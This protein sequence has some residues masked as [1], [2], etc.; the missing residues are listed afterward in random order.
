MLLVEVR[1]KVVSKEDGPEN[2]KGPDVGM[3]AKRQWTKQLRMLNLR[4][5]HEGCHGGQ[6]DLR[7]PNGLL[8]ADRGTRN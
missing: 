6:I 7:H 3:E 4:V 2:G 1:G 5:I 8:A